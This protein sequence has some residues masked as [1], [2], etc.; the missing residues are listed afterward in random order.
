VPLVA[1]RVGGLPG[2]VG[3]AALLVPPL[4]VDALDEAV[5]ALLDDPRRRALLA[6]AGPDQAATWPTETDTLDQVAAVYAELASAAASAVP[7]GP[8]G[9]GADPDE[10]G[11]DP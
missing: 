6:A 5:R 4:D 8:D 1:T 3:E 2:L 11:A 7:S 9:P 10:S